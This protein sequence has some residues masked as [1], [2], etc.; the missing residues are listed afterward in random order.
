MLYLDWLQLT[1]FFFFFF[2]FFFLNFNH[3]SWCKSNSYSCSYPNSDGSVMNIWQE[4]DRFKKKKKKKKK[5]KRGKKKKKKKKKKKIKKNKKKITE[6]ANVDFYP[7][8]ISMF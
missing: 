5:K 7:P 2:F 6:N 4:G 8:N 1:V 3:A